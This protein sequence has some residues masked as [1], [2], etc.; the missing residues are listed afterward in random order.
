MQQKHL[1]FKNYLENYSCLSTLVGKIIFKNKAKCISQKL[2]KIKQKV[3]EL[4][5]L[6][7]FTFHVQWSTSIPAY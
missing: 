4:N 2:K 6:L 7:E 1:N 5:G 3:L